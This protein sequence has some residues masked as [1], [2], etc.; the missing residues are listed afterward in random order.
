MSLHPPPPPYTLE[1]E[2]MAAPMA[3]AI[4]APLLGPCIQALKDVGTLRQHL[5][6]RVDACLVRRRCRWNSG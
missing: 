1:E 2:E 3:A 5:A 4:G 6:A